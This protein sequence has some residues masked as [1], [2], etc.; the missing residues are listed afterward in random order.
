MGFT[1]FL[2]RG[3]D[4]VKTEWSLVALAYNCRRLVRLTA[5]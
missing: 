4:Q 3:L 5:A 2:L 1:R